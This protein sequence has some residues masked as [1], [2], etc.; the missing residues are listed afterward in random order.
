[1]S[2]AK[3]ETLNYFPLGFCSF[4]RKLGMIFEGIKIYYLVDRPFTQVTPYFGTA[5]YRAD[6]QLPISNLAEEIRRTLGDQYHI[7]KTG[8]GAHFISQFE[9]K[10]FDS[11]GDPKNLCQSNQTPP[12]VAIIT[13]RK[14]TGFAAYTLLANISNL[15]RYGDKIASRFLKHGS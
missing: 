7:Y 14:G 2:Q 4:S 9:P 6:V 8:S 3:Q 13:E 10:E 12:Y 5:F 15:C 11:E 1:Y